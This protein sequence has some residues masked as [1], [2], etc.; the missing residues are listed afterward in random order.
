MKPRRR[1]T[2][3]ES[4][5]ATR[6]RLIESAARVFVRT[7]FDGASVEQIAADAGYSRGAFYS[8]FADKDEIFLEVLSRRRIENAEAIAQ[9]F[10]QNPDAT[11]R[12]AAVR[13]WYVE[14]WRQKEWMTLRMEFLLRALRDRTVRTRLAHVLREELG[15][16]AGLVAL[17]FA[18]ARTALTDRPETVALSLLAVAQGLGTMA[19]VDAEWAAGA[20]FNEAPGLVFNRLIGGAGEER[21]HE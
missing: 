1:L 13:D 11:A 10:R 4:Q 17:H 20:G 3:R 14:Q 16:Y 21:R 7:G 15:S 8:N 6:A 5:E 2:R 12:L 19:L 9:I 18:S